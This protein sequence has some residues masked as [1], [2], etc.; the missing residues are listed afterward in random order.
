M[1]TAYMHVAVQFEMCDESIKEELLY[2]I[3]ARGVLSRCSDRFHFQLV[4]KFCIV[5]YYIILGGC[6]YIISC[7]VIYTF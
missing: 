3:P 6:P 7:V 4:F 2:H 1:C 5:I